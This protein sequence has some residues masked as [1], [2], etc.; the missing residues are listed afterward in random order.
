M[1]VIFLEENVRS[2]YN[3]CLDMPLIWW[4]KDPSLNGLSFSKLKCPHLLGGGG[5]HVGIDLIE[6]LSRKCN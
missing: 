1:K 4:M 5:Q 3:V 6:R 2:I